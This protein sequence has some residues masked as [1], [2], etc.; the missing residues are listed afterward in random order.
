MSLGKKILS[1]FVEFDE[2]PKNMPVAPDATQAVNQD[3]LKFQST[4]VHATV[5]S[6]TFPTAIADVT[7]EELEKFKGYFNELFKGLN[8]PGPDFYEFYMMLNSD[9]M[10]KIPDTT[11]RLIATFGALSY[12]GLTKEK[13][14]S[15]VNHY[16]EAMAKDKESFNKAIGEKISTETQIKQNDIQNSKAMVLDIDKQI[17]EL[18]D[19]KRLLESN[20]DSLNQ[21]VA[22]DSVKHQQKIRAYEIVSNELLNSIRSSVNLIQS[23]L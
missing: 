18:E 7:N 1:T 17:K 9:T 12:Q 6:Q 16:T 10:Q 20:I 23:T 19:K 3:F 13:L 22:A 15:S 5:A 21:S 8:M 4:T 2:K 14:V 11:S